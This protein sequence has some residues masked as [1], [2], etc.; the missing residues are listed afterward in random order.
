[1]PL[2]GPRVIAYL[3]VAASRNVE[4]GFRIQN[5]LVGGLPLQATSSDPPI[6]TSYS[7]NDRRSPTPGL[8]VQ[9][10][11]LN[12]DPSKHQLLISA[13]EGVRAQGG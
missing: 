2:V 4:A 6:P 11:H 3:V 9:P 8:N 13:S 10:D 1:M 12:S 7:I 5:E